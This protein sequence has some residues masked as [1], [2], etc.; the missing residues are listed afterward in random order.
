MPQ[1]LVV[2]LECGGSQQLVIS[3]HFERGH[4]GAW[5]STGTAAGRSIHWK[6]GNEN[7]CK[8]GSVLVIKGHSNQYVL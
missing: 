6:H 5:H 4:K 3:V 8:Y 2:N 7:S 1:W